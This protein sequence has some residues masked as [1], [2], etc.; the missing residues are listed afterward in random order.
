MARMPVPPLPPTYRIVALGYD[1]SMAACGGA[2]ACAVVDPA[3]PDFATVYARP[4]ADRFTLLHEI[5]HLYDVE[6]LSDPVR[7]RLT[8]MFGL[9]PPWRQG[10]GLAGL[11]S[12]SEYAADL[13]A[14]CRMNLTS[15]S[16][17]QISS[18]SKAMAPRRA[19]K[20]CAILVAP[21]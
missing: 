8:R 13:Y 19:R 1:D 9:S 11:R 18:Y 4:D 15:Q 6:I 7:A 16:P 2:Q 21:T 3:T 20:A 5:G 14:R 10:T 17:L 12:P